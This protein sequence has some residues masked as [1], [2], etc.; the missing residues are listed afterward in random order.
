VHDVDGGTTYCAHCATPLI[1]RDWYDV[2][3]WRLD[4]TGAC[5]AC[6]HALPGRFEC[7]PGRF[8]RRRIP[9]RIEPAHA[10][11]SL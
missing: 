10:R 4:E 3:A 11:V 6:G 8:G 1:E 2:L 9:V 7:A 5:R